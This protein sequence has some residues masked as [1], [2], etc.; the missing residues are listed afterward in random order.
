MACHP[1]ATGPGLFRPGERVRLRFID[2]A[3]MT[4][5]DVRI[6]GLRMTVVQVDGQNV[7][8]VV[9]DEFRM[10]A[11]GNLRC[12]LGTGRGPRYTI[13]AETIDRSGYARG[14]LAPR[15]GMEAEFLSADHVPSAPMEDMG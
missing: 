11:G 2:A 7:Q 14:T 4:F 10:G 13:F 3:A 5:Y 15:P 1:R 12:D 6:P 9:V 8:P